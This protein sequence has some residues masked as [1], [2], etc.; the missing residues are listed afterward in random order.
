MIVAFP[1]PE[2]DTDIAVYLHLVTG[3]ET[4]TLM[5]ATGSLDSSADHL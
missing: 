2:T 4:Q 5:V 1:G 3:T